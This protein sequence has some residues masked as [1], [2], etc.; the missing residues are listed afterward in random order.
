MKLEVE[1]LVLETKYTFKIA[2]EARKKYRNFIFRLDWEGLEGLGEAAPQVYYGEDEA[3]V[4]RAVRKV[5]GRLEGDPEFVQESLNRGRLRAEL[6]R[7]ASVRAALD[8]A[9]W[10]LRGKREGKPCYELFGLDPHATPYTSF[11][12][13]FDKPE[14]VREKVGESGPYRI[15]K[16]KVGLPGDIELLDLVLAETGKV[17]RV[18]ANEGWDL[19]TARKLVREMESRGVEFIEQ[20]L[21]HEK[22]EDLATLKQESRVPIILD[23]SVVGPGDVERCRDL[24]HGVNIKLMK[25]GGMT[26]A[27]EMIA[28]AKQR[29]MKVMLGCMIETSVAVTAA[30]HL[31][32]L[33]DFADLDGNLLLAHDPYLGVKVKQ[34]RLVLPSGPGLGVHEK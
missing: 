32:P 12:I 17:V 30:A 3:S 13:G 27:L 7:D 24:G 14:V 25:C 23:E 29:G 6:G 18:D 34:G 16:V 4:I 11:T 5:E 19:P 2:R 21:P 1:P 26:P 22:V 20:P 10:D 8:M 33:V 15:L 31:S 9:L 28:L